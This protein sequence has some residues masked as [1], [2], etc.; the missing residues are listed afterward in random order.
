MRD[1]DSETLGTWKNSQKLKEREREREKERE[2]ERA[3]TERLIG[4]G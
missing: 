3:W 2:R 1:K 4:S